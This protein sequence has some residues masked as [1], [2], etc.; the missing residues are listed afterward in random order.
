MPQSGFRTRTRDE[1]ADKQDFVDVFISERGSL[2]RLALMLTGNLEMAA[3]CV[4]LALRECVASSSVSKGWTFTWT[5]RIVIRNAIRL[6]MGSETRTSR[7]TP[8]GLDSSCS[9][10]PAEDFMEPTVALSVLQLPTIDR[11]V[12]VICVREG[13]TLHDCALLMDRSPRE[14]NEAYTRVA[15]HALRMDGHISSFGDACA[16]AQLS[17]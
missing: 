7:A 8:C 15:D 9:L 14:V 4:V 6:V 1:Y 3:L 2:E 11:L 13:Y 10:C 17:V 16:L 5:R 12:F